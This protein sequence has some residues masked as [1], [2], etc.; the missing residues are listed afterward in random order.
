MMRTRPPCN[1]LLES[2]ASRM[3]VTL[4]AEIAHKNGVPPYDLCNLNIDLLTGEVFVLL[5]DRFWRNTVRNRLAVRVLAC[6]IVH[7]SRFGTFKTDLEWYKLFFG[8]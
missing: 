4:T 6:D 5:S 2:I 3:G 7:Y 8:V 1:K